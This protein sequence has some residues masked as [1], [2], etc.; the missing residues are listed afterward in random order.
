MCVSIQFS[1][2]C[3]KKKKKKK[4]VLTHTEIFRLGIWFHMF[5]DHMLYVGSFVQNIFDIRT[6][7]FALEANQKYPI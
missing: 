1:F 5:K 2:S 3:K 7:F 6:G 4:S